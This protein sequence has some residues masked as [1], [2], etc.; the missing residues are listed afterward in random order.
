MKTDWEEEI[1][2]VNG[3]P[4]QETTI[5]RVRDID[6]SGWLKR[7]QNISMLIIDF[8][9]CGRKGRSQ[10]GNQTCSRNAQ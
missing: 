4:K 2:N 9:L 1:K 3:D 6:T 7:R 5:I 10:D 8:K